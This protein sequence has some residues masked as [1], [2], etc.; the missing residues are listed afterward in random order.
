M[1][2]EA[3]YFR[4]VRPMKFCGDIFPNG[5]IQMSKGFVGESPLKKYEGVICVQARRFE[6]R[7]ASK[8]ELLSS[9]DFK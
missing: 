4:R 9:H 3:A 5:T 2:L 1:P 6:K 7:S 8:L